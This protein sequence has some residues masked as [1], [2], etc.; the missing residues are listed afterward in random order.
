MRVK[1]DD[2][3]EVISGKDKGKRGKV[4]KVLP[5]ENKVVIQGVNIVKRHQRP[6]PQ[7]REGGIIEREAP[8]YASKV[9]LVCPNCD[10]PTR[11]GMR[12]LDDGAKVRFCKKC[13]EIVDKA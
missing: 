6:I 7:L 8:I 2:L 9:M 10:K 4:L 13:G 5:R 11:V 3:V 1:K 12:F